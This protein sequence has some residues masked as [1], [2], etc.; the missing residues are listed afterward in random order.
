MK[1]FLAA[2]AFLLS[3]LA[4]RAG[5]TPPASLRETVN[6]L[7]APQIQKAIDALQANFLSPSAL[8]EA[9]KQKAL[10][11]GL[12]RR[13]SPGA[14]II[15]ADNAK[16]RTDL[17]PFLAE[18]LDDRAGYIRPGTLDAAALSQ[19]DASLASFSEKKLPA[20]ILDLRG[21]AGGSE[22]DSAADFARRFCPKGKMLFSIQKPSAKQERILTSTQE[23]AY[24]GILVVLTDPDTAGAAE[25]L[26][27][28]LRQNA[29][30]MIVGSDTAGEA[31]EFSEVSLGGGKILRVAVSQV[32]LSE[33]AT[34]FPG[35]VKPDIA[36]SLPPGVLADIYAAT[37]D[38]GVSQFV[39]DSGRPRMNEAALV[40]ST[41]PEIENSKDRP[42]P[43]LRDTVLQRAMDLVTAINFSKRQK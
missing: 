23:P 27:A 29:G 37:K 43:P 2:A 10:L 25:A 19:L 41:N 9:S 28:T 18:I 4:L 39:F 36:I 13:L 5:E 22:F 15:T 32:V 8:D 40:A 21:V 7:D 38:K 34:I 12:V 17:V 42:R 20:V 14:A 6:S 26:A 16:G 24:E 3:T 30:A 31:V 11:E 1:L 35:G 33:N